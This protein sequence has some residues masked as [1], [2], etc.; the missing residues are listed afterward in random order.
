MTCSRRG[1]PTKSGTLVASS[2]LR[3]STSDDDVVL[4]SAQV[5]EMFNGSRA[6]AR[7]GVSTAG[8]WTGIVHD[9]CEFLIS[10]PSTL[11]GDLRM[12][13][14]PRSLAQEQTIVRVSSV[15]ISFREFKEG[16]RKKNPR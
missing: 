12:I 14:R 5:L 10:L 11:F 9:F 4:V 1:G 2:V 8:T 15:T 13:V 7:G 3:D 6:R 16:R